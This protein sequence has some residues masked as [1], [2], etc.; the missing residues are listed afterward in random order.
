[1]EGCQKKAKAQRSWLP[2]LQ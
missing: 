2:L 1:M